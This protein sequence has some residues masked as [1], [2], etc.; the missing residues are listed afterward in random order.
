VTATLSGGNYF[1]PVVQFTHNLGFVAFASC[2][3]SGVTQFS[4]TS[5]VKRD[6]KNILL[7]KNYVKWNDTQPYS[8]AYTKTIHFKI[9]NLDIT[10]PLS[11]NFIQPP[12]VAYP[13][14]K[15]YGVKIVKENKSI[16]SNDMRDYILHTRCQSPMVLAVLDNTSAK[17]YP[18]QPTNNQLQYTNPQGY[19]NWVYGFFTSGFGEWNSVEP[20]GQA[21][22]NRLNI[23]PDSVGD[24]AG[25]YSI[26]YNPTNST[27]VL[28][29]LR[30]PLFV[31]QQVQVNY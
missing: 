15:D 16:T 14:D 22:G 11:Y 17:P 1:F 31:A 24:N 27:G 13:Y 25:Q 19:T 18:A 9:Y 7:H 10:K 20:G 30:D 3:T 29:V 6:T 12:A 26:I 5:A 2:W 23:G 8:S 21:A 28:V 4:T